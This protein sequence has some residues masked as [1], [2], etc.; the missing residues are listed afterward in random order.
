[1][2]PEQFDSQVA[3]PL[4]TLRGTPNALMDLLTGLRERITQL[5]A[6]GYT[7]LGLS[8]EGLSRRIDQE[9]QA[10]LLAVDQL[11]ADCQSAKAA[12]EGAIRAASGGPTD[13]QARL[14]ALLEAEQIWRRLKSRF[15]AVADEN[16]LIELERTVQEA[17]DA[18][19]LPSLR[20]IWD[21][22][23]PYLASRHR[24]VDARLMSALRAATLPHLP[25]V[26]R[27]AAA[28]SDEIATG[29]PRLMAAFKR[30]REEAGGTAGVTAILPGWAPGSSV[31][32]PMQPQRVTID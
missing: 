14:L 30:A 9:R 31:K 25:P 22:V 16:L 18:G 28:L 15:D 8:P 7:T 26:E 24:P 21:E 27:R 23:A 20:V 13:P 29:W 32:P 2:T 10:T 6:T 19:D 5:E 12:I 4:N 17:A 1:M 11:E 3:K